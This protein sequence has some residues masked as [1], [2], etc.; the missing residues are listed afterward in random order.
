VPKLLKRLTKLFTARDMH[1]AYID[2]F[3][4]S[5]GENLLGVNIS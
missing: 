1:Y 3:E 5:V 2:V 4:V